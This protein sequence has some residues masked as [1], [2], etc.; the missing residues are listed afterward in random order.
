MFFYRVRNY[1]EDCTAFKYTSQSALNPSWKAAGCEAH[2]VRDFTVLACKMHCICLR[3]AKDRYDPTSGLPE[4]PDAGDSYISTAT[5]NG[6]TINYM[7]I[8]DGSAWE[9]AIPE[10]GHKCWVD[11]ENEQYVYNGSAWAKL[12]WV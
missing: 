3:N 12:A 8:H 9:E 5:A 10:E 1:C 7:Y 4:S 2:T 6:W 11:D